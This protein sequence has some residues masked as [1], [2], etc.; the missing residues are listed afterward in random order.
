MFCF[1][2]PCPPFLQGS[3]VDLIGLPGTE[4]VAAVCRSRRIKVRRLKPFGRVVP[5]SAL[6][7]VL[8]APLK[9]AHQA[10]QLAR[11]VLWDVE[12][13]RA[14]LVQVP[15]SAPALFVLALAAWIR[16]FRLVVDWHNFGHTIL[17]LSLGAAH[18]F[19]RALKA[20]ERTAGPRAGSRHL[21]VTRAM[22]DRL[23]EAWGVE[24]RTLYD[25]PPARFRRLPPDERHA[26]FAR[27]Q[28][29][30]N[31]A[32]SVRAGWA[33]ERAAGGHASIPTNG[34]SGRLC[35]PDRTFDHSSSIPEQTLFTRIVGAEGRAI[36]R[37]GRPKLVVSST[38]WTPDE[39]FGILL[40]ALDAL[41]DRARAAGVA[42]PRI[43]CAITGRGPQRAEYME[44]IKAMETAGRL[45]SVH[46][47]S[48]WLEAEVRSRKRLL[49]S[50]GDC[51]C[52]AF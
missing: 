13:P 6:P 52:L 24:A 37:E 3:K 44:R 22:R 1:P 45:R 23:R 42:C 33:G 14:V 16:P 41:A 26:L 20:F 39:D 10:W 21:C 7:F 35:L 34:E 48:L 31:F 2:P 36:M 4:C 15:P 38:S 18:P 47:Y 29:L 49:G 28:R 50:Y 9:V 32:R 27:M 5:R 43:V 8:W 11:T 19:V 12:R 30:G 46:V 17:A 51:F 40:S 25:R